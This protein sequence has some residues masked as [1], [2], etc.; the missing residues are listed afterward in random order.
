[1]KLGW[2][3]VA[4]LGAVAPYYPHILA[5]DHGWAV[6]LGPNPHADMKYFSSFPNVLAGLVEHLVRRRL[7]AEAS[8]VSVDGLVE[9]ARKE[10]DRAR[11]LC[12]V[13]TREIEFVA[14]QTR[15]EA[16]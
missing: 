11:E 8:I 7:G 3:L 13:A 10:F 15:K 4:K 9:E 14:R 6:R 16:V 5:D 1:M 2:R 12:Q